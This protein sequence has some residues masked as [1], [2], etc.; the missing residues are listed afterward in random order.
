MSRYSN[1][2]RVTDLRQRTVVQARRI[3]P[4]A[5]HGTIR[6]RLIRNQVP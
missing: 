1:S 3:S 4:Q 5:P 2:I 6:K